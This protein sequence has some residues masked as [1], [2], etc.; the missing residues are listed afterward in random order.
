MPFNS[1]PQRQAAKLTERRRENG[2]FAHHGSTQ[3]PSL[4]RR[5]RHG[6]RVRA[7]FCRIH[8]RKNH[9]AIRVPGPICTVTADVLPETLIYRIEPRGTTK[10]GNPTG[11]LLKIKEK[12]TMEKAKLHYS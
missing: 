1:V 5:V 9:L 12:L 6:I 7:S 2:D 10:G 11:D 3:V 4:R 8:R